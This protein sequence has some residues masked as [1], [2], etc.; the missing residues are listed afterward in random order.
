MVAR[1]GRFLLRGGAGVDAA[2][3][4]VLR[5]RWEVATT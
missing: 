3:V 1:V 2:V 5:L 4:P